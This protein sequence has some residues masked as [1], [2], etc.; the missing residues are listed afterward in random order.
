M[1][2][3]AFPRLNNISFWLLPPSL[4][5]LV[6][7]A[8]VEN[9]AGTGWTVENGKQSPICKDRATKHH[10]MRGTP[11]FG[12]NYS[13]IMNPLGFNRLAVKMF[14]TRGQ[15]AWGKLDYST[16]SHQRLNVMQ[17]KNTEFQ[18]WLVGMTDGDGSFSVLR[19]NDK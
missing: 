13:S 1:P 16:L 19:Q 5:L 6:A 7:S 15:S 14:L 9:G 17:P 12:K 8:S 4:I 3:M 18:Q 10:S 11:Q 2:D